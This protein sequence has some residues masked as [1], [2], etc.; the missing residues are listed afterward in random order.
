[1]I[2]RF[3][4]PQAFILVVGLALLSPSL[5]FGESTPAYQFP[6]TNVTALRYRT[7]MSELGV[8]VKVL[9][10]DTWSQ[11]GVSTLH[12][13]LN[14]IPGVSARDS[15]GVASITMMGLDTRATKIM[16][17]GISLFDMTSTQGG[18]NFDAISL[19]QL[20]RIEVI[21]GA[22][23]TLYGANAMAGVIQLI[24]KK[25]Q[26]F[27][28]LRGGDRVSAESFGIAHEALGTDVLF[29]FSHSEDSSKSALDG[30]S[31]LD[32]AEIYNYHLSLKRDFGFGIGQFIYH[33]NKS[34]TDLDQT[35]DPTVALTSLDNPN[36]KS[37]VNQDLTKFIW[38]TSGTGG[39]STQLSYQRDYLTR[40]TQGST[41]YNYQA[42]GYSDEFESVFRTPVGRDLTFLFGL[43]FYKEAYASNQQGRFD[44]FANGSWT[45]PFL[46]LQTG[47]RQE[48]YDL[49][50]NLTADAYQVG[51]SIPVSALNLNVKGSLGQGFRNPTL[52]EK[53]NSSGSL[54][55][56]P[57]LSYTKDGTLAYQL[58]RHTKVLVTVFESNLNHEILYN[59]GASAYYTSASTRRTTGL[60]YT[61][62]LT[63]LLGLDFLSLSYINQHSENVTT[64]AAPDLVPETQ[65]V[66]SAG[67][68]F[69]RLDWGATLTYVGP[70]RD[71]A[72]QNAVPYATFPVTLPRYYV[73][74]TKLTY[75]VNS[76]NQLYLII[77]NL[78][79]Y[80]YQETVGFAQPDR[81]IQVGYQLEF[82]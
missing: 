24:P 16:F 55:N 6:T 61:L 8:P 68:H 21:Q 45:L 82:N 5:I 48:I 31:E 22:M 33:K 72:Y 74:S 12:Q 13:A 53:A 30:G 23:S 51:I 44:Y 28:D 64:G 58:D 32:N 54:L 80:H 60:N 41:N 49:T 11:T 9:T 19:D 7:A 76:E 26:T 77:Q 25:E 62:E 42:T 70:R 18:W 66:A 15:S 52:Y 2:F 78:F 35:Y 29:Q 17:D 1:M 36:Y 79:N 71:T 46:T 59:N 67:T 56:T 27:L 39:T 40:Y 75:H 38:T 47:V 37:F 57:E 14:M 3:S 73:V 43:D 63:Q 65:F 81:V 50:Q 4:T 10:S 69:D 20:D 34:T